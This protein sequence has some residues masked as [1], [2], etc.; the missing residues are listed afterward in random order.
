MRELGPHKQANAI[1]VFVNTPDS[2][3]QQALE[4]AW[5][6]GKKNDII[7]IV[8]VTAWPKI[9]WVAVSSWSKAEIFKVQLRD[10]I[11]ALGEVKRDEMLKL[12]EDH[13]WKSFKRREMKEFEYLANEIEP[14]LWVTILAAILGIAISVGASYYFYRNDPFDAP[15]NRWRR[16]W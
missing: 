10:D 5:I 4:S 12:L 2:S 1:I 9:D 7:V 14:P 11:R 8:G 3:Y 13:T 6:G 15:V 16:K